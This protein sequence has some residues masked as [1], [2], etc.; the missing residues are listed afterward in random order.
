MLRQ[1]ATLCLIPVAL[2]LATGI[3]LAAGPSMAQKEIATA[4]I[5]ATVA[6][7]INALTGVHLHLHHVVNCLVGP[8][9]AGYS[10]KAEALSAYHCNDLGNGAIADSRADPQVH[11]LAETALREAQ[12]GIHSKTMA[13]AHHDAVSVLRTLDAAGE[14]GNK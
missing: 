6:S 5:H 8:H 10:A 7:K 11:R 14:A 3:A 1:H 9:G 2:A 4:K 12:A 13:T